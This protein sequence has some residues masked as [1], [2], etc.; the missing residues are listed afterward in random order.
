MKLQ[1]TIYYQF[2]KDVENFEN[3]S[4]KNYIIIK[5]QLNNVFRNL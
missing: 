1:L 5:I 2:K 3:I 4:N